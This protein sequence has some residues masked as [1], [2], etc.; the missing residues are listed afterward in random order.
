MGREGCAHGCRP[1]VRP[2][3][4]GGR[5]DGHRDVRVPKDCGRWPGTPAV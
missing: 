1:P 5:G 2:I 4:R 3:R